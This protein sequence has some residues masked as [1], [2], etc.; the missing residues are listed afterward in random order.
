MK[1]ID[2][3]ILAR[4]VD[5]A[6]ARLEGDWVVIGGSALLLMGCEFRPTVD[7]D[8]AGPEKASTDHYLRLLEIAEE[9][10][11]PV[12]AVN[13]AGAFFLRRIDGWQK[14]VVPYKVGAKGRILVPDTTLFLLL[15]MPR[16]TETDLA[17]CLA[18]L[19]LAGLK[20][21]TFDG[22]LLMSALQTSFQAKPG[23]ERWQRLELLEAGVSDLLKSTGQHNRGG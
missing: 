10:D 12:E 4:F 8:I 18:V 19:K 9:L 6:A 5:E 15:K 2:A 1:S 20:G 3:E 22:V 7:I 13:Q 21:L 11:L 23:P 17:D 14:H 16:L